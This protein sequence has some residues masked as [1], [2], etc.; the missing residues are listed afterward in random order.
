[1]LVDA[2]PA[3]RK[4]RLMKTRGLSPVEVDDLIGAQAPAAGKRAKSH[5][6]I[7]NDGSK[8]ALERRARAVWS[9]LLGRAGIV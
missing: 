2:P 1:M 7:D 8:D 9:E 5:F 3:V 4:D 6:V